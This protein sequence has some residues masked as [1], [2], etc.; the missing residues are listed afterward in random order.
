M[1]QPLRWDKCLDLRGAEVEAFAH[2]HFGEMHRRVL[3]LA[4]AGFD[5]R[6]AQVA[7]V[8]S[9]VLGKRLRACF[10]REERPDPAPELV[11]RASE[12]LRVLTELVPDSHVAKVEVFASDG[13][14]VGGRRATEALHALDLSETT[15]VVVDCSALSLGIMFP[16][17]RLLLEAGPQASPRT[18]VHIMVTHHPAT[19]EAIT[20]ISSDRADPIAGFRGALGMDEQARAAKLWLPHLVRG[21]RAVLD[22]IHASVRPHDTCPVLPFPSNHWRLGDKL[23][24]E[25]REEL[26]GAWDVDSRN[27]V[28]AAESSPLDLYRT[29]LRIADA[30]SSVFAGVGGSLVVLSPMG[31]KLLSMGALMAALERDF[32]VVYVESIGYTVD[33]QELE[34]QA[35]QGGELV[36][37]WLAG[38]AYPS[39]GGA[40]APA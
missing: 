29:L 17:V 20:A 30:R 15:D 36:H 31:S 33:W 35:G 28:Y 32:P 16:M 11:E 14:V 2:A 13:A 34:A 38:E 5:P 19:D 18:N 7:R 23:L 1:R 9:A 24:E 27:I 4:G 22:R 39:S 25:Y 12:N 26:E 6:A 10:I 37:L 21:K 3:V 40:G 8:L